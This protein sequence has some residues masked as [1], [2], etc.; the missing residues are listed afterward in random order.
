MTRKYISYCLL[1]LLLFIFLHSIYARFYSSIQSYFQNKISEK[2]LR[3]EEN[4]YIAHKL[5]IY[6]DY[7]SIGQAEP[8]IELNK[9]IN[10]TQQNLNMQDSQKLNWLHPNFNY[11]NTRF[12]PDNQLNTLNV[13]NLKLAF[14]LNTDVFASIQ[15]PPI[16]ADGFIF[17][18][19][20]FNNVYAF[21][22]SNGKQY[23]H[24]RYSNPTF[25]YKIQSTNKGISIKE[26]KIF[27]ATNDSHLIALNAKNGKEIWKSIIDKSLCP[28]TS[29]PIAINDYVIVGCG[30]NDFHNF[31]KAFDYKNG[32]LIWEFYTAPTKGQEGKWVSN[33][34]LGMSRRNIVK[35]KENFTKSSLKGYGG[36]GVVNSPSIDIKTKTIFFVTGDPYPSQRSDERPGDNLYSNSIIALDL[37]TGKYKW[38]YQYLPHDNLDLDFLAP[39]IL[40]DD[41]KK[42][43]SIISSGKVGRIFV[44]NRNT[45]KLK[46]ISNAMIDSY[47]SNTGVLWSPM[48]LD[49]RSNY[50]YAMTIRK[51]AG[52]YKGA[53]V[54]TNVDNGNIVFKYNT[55]KPLLGGVLATKGNLV[56]F[57]DGEGNV[58]A[59]NSRNGNL[60]WQS[61]CDAGANG[62]PIAYTVNKK[63]FIAI[64]CG[65]SA[66]FNF[67]RGNKFYVYSL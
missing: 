31:I 21:D 52:K 44:H 17:V 67:K 37:D 6:K 38:H 10:I 65:G 2:K 36:A 48:S 66:N 3:Q 53:L 47:D 39:T 59:L 25:K 51:V 58:K 30:N 45:G 32:K 64:G 62:V 20:S 5:P 13:R 1:V 28:S 42:I 12:Y 16:V 34:V 60:L 50:A 40:F 19:T 24:Y 15:S 33:D 57:G 54:A 8:S 4:Y 14:T 9:Q 63:Q 43:P 23:W 46:L 11:S 29:A 26:N 61:K 27:L 49:P 35:E 41:N 56:F 18:S 55:E 7:D 22:A